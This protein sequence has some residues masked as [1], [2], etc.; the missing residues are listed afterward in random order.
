M[1]SIY[2]QIK[3]LENAIERKYDGL[4]ILFDQFSTLDALYIIKYYKIKAKK[5]K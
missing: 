2:V 3:F 4:I 1:P 5:E